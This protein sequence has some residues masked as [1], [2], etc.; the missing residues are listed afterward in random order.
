[1][2]EAYFVFCVFF[3][4]GAYYK[5]IV[6]CLTTFFFFCIQI[7]RHTE[8]SSLNSSKYLELS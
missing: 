7:W 5:K 6:L 3:G 1:V 8:C 4:L 2:C